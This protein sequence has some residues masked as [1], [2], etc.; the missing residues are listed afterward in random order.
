MVAAL[1]EDFG[2]APLAVER[3]PPETRDAELL[4][5]LLLGRLAALDRVPPDTRDPALL[6]DL[7][8]GR[9]L[10]DLRDCETC[11]EA[12]RERDL[13]PPEVR[14]PALLARLWRFLLFL[15]LLDLFDL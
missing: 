12:E 9:V 5:D 14:D 10:A 6:M 11:A 8:L 3:V 13:V 15:L 2:L 7:L 1:P 4:M